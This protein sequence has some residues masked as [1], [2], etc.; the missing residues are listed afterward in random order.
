MKNDRCA[1]LLLR[2]L[3][4]S[5]NGYVNSDSVFPIF[6]FPITAQFQPLVAEGSQVLNYL[7]VSF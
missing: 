3:L 7:S 2:S 4:L 5:P 1:R 6:L